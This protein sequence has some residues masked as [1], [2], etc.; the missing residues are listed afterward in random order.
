MLTVHGAEYGETNLNTIRLDG[1]EAIEKVR[2]LPEKKNSP[3]DRGVHSG[4]SHVCS[5]DLDIAAV[6]GVEELR[7]AVWTCG[8]D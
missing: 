6:F 8:T 2:L 1:N 3:A 5:A 7:E 4:V